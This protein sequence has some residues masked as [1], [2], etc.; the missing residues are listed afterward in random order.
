MDFGNDFLSNRNNPSKNQYFK[1][2]KQE[3]VNVNENKNDNT[4][5]NINILKNYFENINININDID[6]RLKQENYIHKMGF[7]NLKKNNKK[8][9]QNFISKQSNVYKFLIK[10]FIHESLEDKY[11][12][13]IDN[14][15]KRIN[16]LLTL[17]V[18]EFHTY[19]ELLYLKDVPKRNNPYEEIVSQLMS[20]IN[21]QYICLFYY[22]IYIFSISNEFKPFLHNDTIHSLIKLK[23]VT[24]E[25]IKNYS[26][27]ILK[28]MES[29][30]TSKEVPE[31]YKKR[32]YK[33]L[34]S[35]E[36]STYDML[37]DIVQYCVKV[38][39]KKIQKD[40]ENKI[41]NKKDLENENKKDLENKNDVN[42]NKN[43]IEDKK[44]YTFNMLTYGSYTHHMIDDSI[45]YNDIDIY[46]TD[47]IRFLSSIMLMFHIILDI[48]VDILKIP[49]II[50]HASLR[51]KEVHFT[52]CIYIDEYT[53]SLIPTTIIEDIKFVDPVIQFLNN[54]RMNSELKRI[55]LAY[56]DKDNFIKKFYTLINYINKSLKLDFKNLKPLD[57]EY[58]Q[59]GNCIVIDL[60]KL[61][62]F[63][64]K[65]ND[66]VFPKHKFLIVVIETQPKDFL[67]LLNRTDVKIYKQ[68]YALFNEI[69][70]ECLNQKP[71]DINSASNVITVLNELGSSD[72][73]LKGNKD[74]KTKKTKKTKKK[75]NILSNDSSNSSSNSSSSIN[76]SSND[77]INVSNS[78]LLS[79]NVR[80]TIFDRKNIPRPTKIIQT[81]FDPSV[82][83]IIKNNNVIIMSNFTT[84]TYNVKEIN[85]AEIIKNKYI[86]NITKE[87][88][89]ASY[90]LAGILT[91]DKSEKMKKNSLILLFRFMRGNIKTKEYKNLN[92]KKSNIEAYPKYK[93]EGPHNELKLIP[94]IFK[95]INF[96]KKKDIEVFE[97][98][99]DFLET[100]S[101]NK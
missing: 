101:Y 69:I 84:D 14:V 29:T 90:I 37:K 78:D 47:P 75:L 10:K 23:P 12:F 24:D 99:K 62:S 43:N 45:K 34:T 61:Y 15:T 63:V 86:S 49:Y 97:N 54:V 73:I 50:G 83:D 74:K 77:F 19:K 70:V 32:L 35:D 16:N 31:F 53:M 79:N 55:D 87:S 88:I 48:N 6:P 20:L 95:I 92:D 93:N 11:K 91:F 26:N 3:K 33:D 25:N 57:Y 18:K 64:E 1:N 71:H 94:P 81:E 67:T 42:V 59:F 68:Y 36:Q 27:F 7:I 41:K 8:F 89:L 46:H 85:S 66:T 65:K 13:N 98:Y 100:T 56:D 76:Y 82:L 9:M 96:Y 44:K 60:E 39:Q 40:L 28:F 52:D 51:Y 22:N 72:T 80:Q 21:Y 5:Y 4:I 30:F 38:S 58:E 2:I 17:Q